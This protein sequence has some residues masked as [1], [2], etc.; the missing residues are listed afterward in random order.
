MGIYYRGGA[1]K[2]LDPF[3]FRI[4]WLEDPLEYR[5]I[6]K[7]KNAVYSL[8][9]VSM[10][11]VTDYTPPYKSPWG[12]AQEADFASIPN[13]L[14]RAGKKYFEAD[15][16]SFEIVWQED[17][18]G[19]YGGVVSF[20]RD[21]THVYVH[22]AN[23]VPGAD[24]A[25]FTV[26]EECSIAKDRYHIYELNGHQHSIFPGLDPAT[27]SCTENGYGRIIKDAKQVYVGNQLL[28]GFD[29]QT[30]EIIRPRYSHEQDKASNPDI[31]FRDAH[32][33]AAFRWRGGKQR[34]LVQLPIKDPATFVFHND[35]YGTDAYYVYRMPEGSIH[36]NADPKKFDPHRF[37]LGGGFCWRA[38]EKADLMTATLLAIFYGIDHADIISKDRAHVYFNEEIIP[39]ADPATYNV[40]STSTFEGR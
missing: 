11:Q 5:A 38:P 23:P 21:K 40:M 27:F 13:L 10:F 6:V 7:D 9:F 36:Q 26:L 22:D 17:P 2:G 28:D 29:P 30:F 25:T 20:A 24:P 1:L 16:D 31:F 39:G 12:L 15:P 37:E 33:V 3:T 34:E 32:H 14:E 18:V 19:R 4:L 35:C 8:D